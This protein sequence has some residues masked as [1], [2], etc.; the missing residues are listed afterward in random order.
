[1][2]NSPL[3]EIDLDKITYNAEQIV[4]RCQKHNIQ[5]LGVTK[6][7]SALPQIVN[8]MLRGGIQGLADARLE[9]I[10]SLR[11]NGFHQ[12]ITMLRIP[13]LSRT[14]QVAFSANASINSELVV[15]KAL[16]LAA[17]GGRRSHEIILMVDVGDLREGVLP[18][19][20]LET[21]RQISLMKGVK[22]AGLGTN[23]GCFGGVLPSTNNL[24]LLAELSKD[25]E[26]HVGIK[27]NVVSGGGTSTLMLIDNHTIPSGINQ[28]RVGEG[29]LLG[30]DTTHNCVIPYLSQDAFILKTEVIEVKSKPSVPIGKIGR[31]AFGGIP[32]FEDRGTRKRAI[33]A[34]GMQ[35]VDVEG[36]SPLDE[37][38]AILGA[39]SD[40]MILDVEDMTP[41][42][43]VGS[44]IGFRLNYHG[45]L[46]LCSSKYVN[47]IYKGGLSWLNLYKESNRNS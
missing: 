45:M 37:R 10:V 36:I 33:V 39:S 16:S 31:N 29:I 30:T 32:V 28:I 46:S 42:I 6:G 7:F 11:S 19:N 13:R 17:S 38:I 27:L 26:K 12:H 47:K 25:I 21:A 3:L 5:V 4:A 18:E 14:H 8:A 1:M 41:E 35:D 34:L 23:M 20:V 43:K 9:N 15:V 24:S 44:Q 2:K 40:H 22:L